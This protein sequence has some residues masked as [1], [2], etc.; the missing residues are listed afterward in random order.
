[1][2][3]ISK[4]GSYSDYLGTTVGSANKA[5]A[6]VPQ[7]GMPVAVFNCPTRRKLTSFPWVVADARPEMNVD[8]NTLTRMGRSDYAA[9]GGSNFTEL[10]GACPESLAAGDA[11]TDLGNRSSA[12]W[13][14]YPGTRWDHTGGVIFCRSATKMASVRHGVA[15]TY[16]I[17]ERY[18][19]PDAYETGAECADDQGWDQGYDFDTIRWTGQGWYDNDGNPQQGSYTPPSRDTPGY[20]GCDV[21]FGSA[22]ADGFSMVTCDGAVHK[23]TYNID[24]DVHRRL[25]DCRDKTPVDLTVLAK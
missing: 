4:L 9:C 14:Q 12:D 2:H 8:N 11:L 16:L 19:C 21:Q 25:G 7:A 5:T 1:M 22:H 20:G 13:S 6:A 24:Q 10:Y 23:M 17:G 15:C 3:D 18:A